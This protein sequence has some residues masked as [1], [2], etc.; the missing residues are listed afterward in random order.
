MQI[1]TNI[2]RSN[3]YKYC[4]PKTQN[5]YKYIYTYKTPVIYS[6]SRFV[7]V[8]EVWINTAWLT[9]RQPNGNMKKT[10]LLWNCTPHACSL[11]G[12]TKT[13][14][15]L[16]FSYTSLLQSTSFSCHF[17]KRIFQVV[18]RKCLK[19]KH[20]FFSGCSF[21]IWLVS[22]IFFVMV[23]VSRAYYKSINF[24]RRC[25]LASISRYYFE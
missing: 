7:F 8:C 12:D 13:E 11:D 17:C 14:V 1:E 16:E 18:G 15:D 10:E 9:Q 6:N 24:V 4:D 20:V 21:A 25:A 2:S 22:Y 3:I 5:I 23:T 19:K